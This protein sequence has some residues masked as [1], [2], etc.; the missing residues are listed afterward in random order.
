MTRY[1]CQTPVK[2]CALCGKELMLNHG[3][4]RVSRSRFRCLG[5]AIGYQF[6]KTGDRP[7]ARILK[8][9]LRE[10][11]PEVVFDFRDKFDDFER[12]QQPGIEVVDVQECGG[13]ALEFSSADEPV[14]QP[15]GNLFFQTCHLSI[16]MQRTGEPSQ[17][18]NL[19][20]RTTSSTSGAVTDFRL[21]TYSTSTTPAPSKTL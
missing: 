2:P 13:I 21:Q 18:F 10:L 3:G 7:K 11:Y 12:S 5:G 6:R 8:V 17:S 16:T 14:T 15:A 9:L 19:S 4:H 20:G 1:G